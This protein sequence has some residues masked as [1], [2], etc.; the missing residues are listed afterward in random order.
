VLT[1]SVSFWSQMRRQHT[2]CANFAVIGIL[3]P[4]LTSYLRHTL[5]LSLYSLALNL[6]GTGLQPTARG[7]K[8]PFQLEELL[9]L[10]LHDGLQ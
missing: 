1:P 2:Y 3:S 5:C 6:S 10:F 4:H 7:G 8:E 9:G